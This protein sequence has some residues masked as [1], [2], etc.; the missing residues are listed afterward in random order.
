M[1]L[2]KGLKKFEKLSRKEYF[3]KNQ[4]LSKNLWKASIPTVADIFDF[5][6]GL[7]NEKIS[8][9]FN[10]FKNEEEFTKISQKIED[11]YD[12][13]ESSNFI[14]KVMA[15]NNSDIA[16]AG[17]FYKLLMASA[18]DLTLDEN[19]KDCDSNGLEFSIN[20][21]SKDFIK[22]FNYKIKFMFIKE[23]NDFCTLN[24]EDF[25][26]WSKKNKIKTIHVNT[27]LTC[28]CVND[29]GN[30]NR[31]ICQKCAGKLP[32]GVINIGTFTTLMV[33]ESATQSALSSM[34]KGRKENIND[35]LTQSYNGGYNLKEIKEWINSIVEN[36]NISEKPNVS[37]R[38]Y[39]LAL[40]SRIRSD[41]SG[42][43]ISSLKGS[44]ARSDNIFGSYIFT[45]N[46]KNFEKMI[47]KE[48]FKDESLKL[49]IA[50]NNFE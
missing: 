2:D 26:N 35:L 29:W 17:Y 33:T 5:N 1:E 50:I 31:K 3:K 6:S 37:S 19:I 8:A 36:L 49:K 39:E 42:P 44:I 14:R 23:L 30:S 27:P 41:E 11:I 48:C 12:Q 4:E 13:D 25:I 47:K 20:E 40:M 7:E 22:T 10:F 34:N 32:E 45:P 16:E 43:Y 21:E 28:N 46:N 18:D 24:F 9:I 15:S 38:F